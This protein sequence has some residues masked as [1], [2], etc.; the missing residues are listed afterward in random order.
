MSQLNS[1]ADQHS[2]RLSQIHSSMTESNIRLETVKSNDESVQDIVFCWLY[3]VYS[4]SPHCIEIGEQ[5]HSAYC[6]RWA[7]DWWQGYRNAVFLFRF[8]WQFIYFEKKIDYRNVVGCCW[9]DFVVIAKQRCWVRVDSAKSCVVCVKAYRFG[10]SL[11]LSLSLDRFLIRYTTINELT[12]IHNDDD[13]NNDKCSRS[14]WRSW[15]RAAIRVV[16]A[17]HCSISRPNS[18]WRGES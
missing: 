5:R 15:L 10:L 13:N 6:S 12:T 16:R 14:R 8:W 17:K 2:E 1:K 4:F 9:F 3:T 7:F 11:S 18:R